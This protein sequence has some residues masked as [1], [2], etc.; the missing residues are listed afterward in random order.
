MRWLRALLDRFGYVLWKKDF[1]IYGV[2]PFLDIQR[3]SRA[4]GIEIQTFFDAG[5]NVGQTA[6]DALKEFPEALIYSFEPHPV[7]FARLEKAVRDPRVQAFP[8]ALSDGDGEIPFFEYAT[9]GGGTHVNST[10][11]NSSFPRHFGLEQPKRI[12][13]SSTTIDHFCQE[14]GVDRIDVLKLDIEGA[15]LSALKGAEKMLRKDRVRFVYFEYTSAAPIEGIT[16]GALTPIAEYLASFG[17]ALIATYT[18]Y[19]KPEEMYVVANALFARKPASAAPAA[20]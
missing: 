17:F 2:L 6:E 4:W 13:A 18:D 8:L 14:H 3:L 12:T 9:A 20:R 5:A 15:E 1:L 16:G 19:V 7:T 10:V 11:P